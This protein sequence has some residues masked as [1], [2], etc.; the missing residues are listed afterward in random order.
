MRNVEGYQDRTIWRRALPFWVNLADVVTL[1]LLAITI[2]V[3]ETGG[4]RLWVGGVRVSVT[5]PWRLLALG[6]L[7]AAVRHVLFPARSL[8]TRMIGAFVLAGRGAASIVAGRLPALPGRSL[9]LKI[10]DDLLLA[11]RSSSAYLRDCAAIAW[12]SRSAVAL[13][14][15][16]VF[17]RS[18]VFVWWEQ[19]YFDSDQAVVGLMAKHLSEGRAFPLFYYGQAYMLGV[20]AWLAAPLFLVLGPSVFALHLPLLALN[21]LVAVALIVLLQREMGLGA[22]PALA[23]SAFFVLAPPATAARLLEANGGS[24]EPLLYVLLLWATRRR[25]A[26][27]GSV[28][29]FGFLHREFTLYGLVALIVLAVPSRPPRHLFAAWRQGTAAAAAFLMVWVAVQM[30]A[31]V[32]NPR[33][34]GTSTADLDVNRT[35]VGELFA[36]HVCWSPSEIPSRLSDLRTRHVGVLLGTGRHQLRHLGINSGTT[37]QGL[38]GLGSIL[39]LTSVAVLLRLAKTARRSPGSMRTSHFGLYLILVGLVS[40]TLYLTI[41]CGE[42]RLETMRYDLLAIYAPVGVAA[43]FFVSERSRAWRYPVV[44]V[45]VLWS[46]VS[47]VSH[48][49]LL[50]EYASDPPADYAREAVDALAA[51]GVRFARGRYWIAYRL[52]FVAKEWTVIAS[53]DHVRIEEYQGRAD[54]PVPHIRTDPCEG[55]VHLAGEFYRCPR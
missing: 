42:V 35:N 10:R 9:S 28:L 47:V 55:G 12:R 26:L 22:W 36:H 49:H 19:V 13:A 8:P 14:V 52:T 4:F 48:G 7:V 53:D 32:S 21:V 46:T 2:I 54:R 29:G 18:L 31:L 40:V 34:P 24:V 11:A 44:A 38:T 50:W 16:A 25:P 27:F 15:L 1:A 39:L 17:A 20:Q 23:A 5:T 33:G 6:G 43:M 3:S 37:S 30:A 45:L 51:Q 41:G